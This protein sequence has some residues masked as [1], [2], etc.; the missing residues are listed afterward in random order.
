MRRS[1]NP[2]Y[3]CPFYNHKYF[4]KS[5]HP[6][7]GIYQEKLLQKFIQSYFQNNQPL[8]FIRKNIKPNLTN[9]AIEK[10]PFTYF[11]NKL[12]G[13]DACSNSKEY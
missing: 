11:Q 3:L 1:H 5:C 7:C 4:D 8:S 6:I 12:L 13:Q 10:G 2:R 9:I